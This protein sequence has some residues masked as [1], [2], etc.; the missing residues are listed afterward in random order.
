VADSKVTDLTAASALDGT[1]LLPIVQA[2]ASKKASVDQIITAI[3]GREN[4]NA[5]ITTPAAGFAADA[6]VAGSNCLIPN[7][8]L[9]AKTIYRFRCR[10]SKTGAGIATPILIVRIGTAG[11]VADNARITFTL[12]AGTAVI[13]EGVIEIW[14]TFQSVGGGTA[15]VIE[16]TCELRH[17]LPTTGLIS[18]GANESKEVA[19]AGFDST[20]ANS[21]IGISL[22]AGSAALWTVSNVQAR[23]DNLA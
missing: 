18:A 10:V 12:S 5:A 2:A 7:G 20:V 19:S 21:I 1:E 13:D 11:T 4:N 8:K 23:I 15:A 14:V 17:R 6:Y 16:G 22:N 9:Q 3:G